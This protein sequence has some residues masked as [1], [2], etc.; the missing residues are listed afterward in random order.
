MGRTG[1]ATF[2]IDKWDEKPWYEGA[3]GQKLTRATVVKTYHGDLEGEG[4]MEYVMAYT[5]AKRAVYVGMEQVVGS[6]AGAKGSFVMQDRG[7]FE[8]GV[9]ASSFEIVEGSGTDQLSGIRGRAS[10]DAVE[11]DEQR[12]SIEYDLD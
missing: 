10:V 3:N 7:T 12:L 5:D 6:L 8:D 11:A 9:A 1:S 4:T 2:G